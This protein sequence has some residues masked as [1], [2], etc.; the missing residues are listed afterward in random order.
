M[1]SAPRA[2]L[3]RAAPLRESA[4]ALLMQ[5]LERQGNAAEALLVYESLRQRLREELGVAPAEPLQEAYRR[6]LG[7]SGA[8]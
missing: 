2:Q 8:G 4:S 3:V 7:A 6:L 5:A 1:P